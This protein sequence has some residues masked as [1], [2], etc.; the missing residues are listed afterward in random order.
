MEC[1]RLAGSTRRLRL[2]IFFLMALNYSRYAL[3]ILSYSPQTKF[4]KPNLWRTLTELGISRTKP[5][6]RGCRAGLRKH[7]PLPSIVL[8]STFTSNSTLQPSSVPA[9]TWSTRTFSSYHNEALL[10]STETFDGENLHNLTSTTLNIQGNTSCS[11]RSSNINTNIPA[12]VEWNHSVT[13]FPITSRITDRHQRILCNSGQRG[14]RHANLI[15]IVTSAPRSPYNF[16]KI[17]LSNTRSMVN[18][19]DEINT[20]ITINKCNIAVITESWLS[21]N[22]TNALVSIPGYFCIRKDRPNDQRGGGLCT[23][24]KA[25]L[26]FVELND[27]TDEN[28][29]TQ[30]FLLKPERL[31]RGINSII[32]ATVYHPPH[33]NNNAL[34]NHLFNSL[35][36][37]LARFPNAGIIILGD[38]NQ[39][40]PGTLIS[41]FGLKQV[42]KK[43][44]RRNNILDK[45]FT[46]MSE[47]YDSVDILPPIGQSDHSCVLL[48]SSNQYGSHHHPIYLTKRKCKPANKLAFTKALSTINWSPLYHMD[49][50]TNQLN[51]FSHIL[52]STMEVHLP[53][54]K[55]KKHPKDKP[56][57]TED[58]KD[59]ISKRQHAWSSGHN[60]QFKFYRNKVNKLCKS[61]RRKYY[62]NN[63][64]N[65]MSQDSNKWWKNVKTVAGLSISE[66]LTSISHDGQFKKGPELAELIATSFCDV[67][68]SLQP[69]HFDK[70]PVDFVPESFIITEH[71]VES[72]LAKLNI[73][74]A[75][76]PDDIPN[77]VLKSCAP[78]L[79]GP[80]CSIFN[81]SVSQ[82]TIPSL[83]KCADVIPVPKVAKPK[84]ID[85]DLRP[86][87]LTP[88]LS[89]VLESIVS[90][91]LLKIITPYI[92]SLQFGNTKNC[93]TTHAL[94][95]LTHNW[96][97]ALDSP[98][99]KTI[100]AC[101]I[102][103]SKAFDRIDH[104]ILLLK[105]QILGVPPILLNWCAD[106]LKDRN[107]RVKLGQIKSSWRQLNGSVP[108]GTKLGPIFF[109]IM[110]NDLGSHLTMYKYVDDCTVY[111]IVSKSTTSTLQTNIDKISEWTHLNNMKLN[112]KK[113]KEL[114]ISF[115]KRPVT[116]QKLSSDQKQIDIVD[117]FKLLGVTISSNLTWNS[118]ITDICTKASKRL[119]A[120]R[121]LKRSG[122]PP[123]DLITV[124]CSFIR[125]V[126]EYASQ[127]WHFSLPHY[128]NDEVE[129]IQCFGQ[130]RY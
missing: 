102:D 88:V 20:V 79:A 47:N 107:L 8:N 109:L 86:I 84:S 59:A 36:S 2:S 58:I 76:G 50:V 43:P 62:N 18:K 124:Y 9:S 37:A 112:V 25:D 120:L 26:D 81:A 73:H 10:Y 31:P 45:V 27:L 24:I 123:K 6:R 5:T 54:H 82:G 56:W 92:D 110:I 116:L 57:I 114:R 104:N 13:N 122:A 99:S 77:W 48:H 21:S 69:L 38:F 91:W 83:W 15:N 68:N 35:D 53:Q 129:S 34:R 98:Q 3:T 108:Q 30:W 70:I 46:S 106:F 17:F 94:I 78:I 101:M 12:P 41:S 19:L 127:V 65:T 51:Y 87:S 4:L 89:K 100:R 44:T 11:S 103:F 32:L 61:A 66:P 16:P 60:I 115:S 1:E 111:E 121:I 75:T 42:V 118:H 40:N 95:H 55:V 80:I 125:P 93:S 49:S 117:N 105:L 63:I 67:A 7:R 96:L 113:T 14:S 29:E 33:N 126:V 28:F 128:L 64:L 119:Y 72:E 23:Y 39:F 130:T 71:Q 90:S 52:S 85:S 22:I 74:K 97:K